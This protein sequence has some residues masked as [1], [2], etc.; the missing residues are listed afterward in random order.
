MQVII[1]KVFIF[2]S[3]N[4][5]LKVPPALLSGFILTRNRQKSDVHNECVM[6]RHLY[7]LLPRC[8]DFSS[9]CTDSSPAAS[10]NKA[11][12][13]IREVLADRHT[14]CLD[15]LEAVRSLGEQVKC[16]SADEV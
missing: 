11:E 5:Q 2:A 7:L 16:G 8:L 13:C 10:V 6:V 14:I 3:P 15:R 1:G 4:L 12:R 9:A